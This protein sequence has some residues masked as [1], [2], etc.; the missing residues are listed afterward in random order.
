MLTP[1]SMMGSG[2][3][4]ASRRLAALGV[5]PGNRVAVIAEPSPFALEVVAATAHIGATLVPLSPS[6]PEAETER[7]LRRTK[8][9]IVL[10]AGSL[11]GAGH[12]DRPGHQPNPDDAACIVFTSGSTGEPKGIVLTNR[13]IE[14]SAAAA[15]AALRLTQ[16]DR[17]LLCLPLHHVGGLSTIYRA[18][19]TGFAVV[20]VAPFEPRAVI[21]AIDENGVTA[22]SLVPTMLHR[23]L[24]AG[25][26]APGS[27]RFA[28]VG[29]AP[30]PRRLLDEAMSRGIPVAPTYGMTETASQAATLP[31]WGVA[32]GGTVGTA[33]PGISITTGDWPSEPSPPG[34]P[35]RIWIRGEAVAHETIDG[36]LA[37]E[38]G[39]LAT[40]DAGSLDAEGNLT[41]LG[42][43]DGSIITGGDNVSPKQ[44]EEALLRMSVVEQAAVM[45]IPDEERGERVVAAVVLNEPTDSKALRDEL[46]GELPPHAVPREIVLMDSLPHRLLLRE[47]LD[48]A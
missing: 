21:Q 36:P 5:D 4:L 12:A 19:H 27:L 41:V 11:D 8:P 2:L 15:E 44:V 31:P 39:W 10:R 37:A 9:K 29:G 48:S 7:L 42:R 23:L 47:M 45:G 30:C 14:A 46:A 43:L 17:W 3:D 25:W 38:D 26:E 13:N 32:P 1:L 34:I 33:L 22:I 18:M 24:E 40:D 35:A 6:A 28:L 20:P 16:D